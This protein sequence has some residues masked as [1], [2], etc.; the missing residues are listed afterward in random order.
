MKLRRV[1]RSLLLTSLFLVEL[2]VI[3]NSAELL[4]LAVL[5]VLLL[6]FPNIPFKVELSTASFEGGE[7]VGE[8]LEVSIE[9]AVK[10][11]GVIKTMHSLPDTFELVEGSNAKGKFIVGMGTIRLS[12]RCVP[13]KRGL[14]DLGKVFFEAENI[15]ATRRVRGKIEFDAEREVKSRVYRVRKVEQRR[16]VARRPAPEI[17]VSRVGVPGTDFREIRK[18]A[19]GDPVKFINW[20]AT[21]KLG[22]LMVNEFERE[23]KKAVWIFLDAN[24]YMLHG[25]LRRNC[26]ETA[27]EVAASLSYYFAARGHRVGFYAVGH[28]LLIYPESGRRQ[29]S[30]I[31]STLV[32]LDVS[33]REESLLSA[34]EKARKYIES[35]KPA[36]IFITR[37]ELSNPM[38][39]VMKAMGRK[40]L[41]VSVIAITFRGYSGIGGVVEDAVRESTL[42]RLRAAGVAVT[43]VE[44]GKAA[45]T[46]LA[47]V[48]R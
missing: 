19:F 28:E 29:F 16:G 7:R 5:P 22:E 47:G 46:V 23:G 39:A 20:K 13:L 44:A 21:A 9:L 8:V 2:A 33:E 17:D 4:K 11:F 3:I 37:V 31:F 36:S 30:K 48:A 6:V 43:E 14:Y 34:V 10:G 45:E 41:P 38:R 35:V 26:F 40:N 42:R 18:Y 25:D 15:F 24:S 1:S 12:Y 32:K 27:V